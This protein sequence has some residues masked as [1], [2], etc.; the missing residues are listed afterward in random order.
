MQIYPIKN[1][2]DYQ[3]ALKEIAPYF[4]NPPADNDPVWDSVDVM[5]TLIEEYE[6]RHFPRA[7]NATAID[8]IQF[9]MDQKGLTPKDLVPCIGQLNRVYEILS[10]KR[11]LTLP[12]IRRLNAVLG[13]P[14]DFLVR[15]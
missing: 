4:D 11:H 1:D 8:A 14:L 15:A 12:M 7:D 5:V 3:R 10:G 6:K 9:F 2:A 13:I